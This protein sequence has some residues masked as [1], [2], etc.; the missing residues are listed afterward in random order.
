M[1]EYL[2]TP[3]PD[4]TAET[5]ADERLAAGDIAGAQ[6][7]LETLGQDFANPDM[8]FHAN[9]KAYAAPLYE[10]AHYMPTETRIRTANDTYGLMASLIELEL[11][12]ARQ[13][14]KFSVE[15]GE[16]PRRVGRINELLVFGLL[17]REGIDI[18]TAAVPIPASR[19]DDES[20]GIDFYLSPV[21][22]GRLDDG[23]PFQV[24][25]TAT[26]DD[27]KKFSEKGIALISV[28]DID[29]RFASNPDKSES[30]AWCMLRELDGKSSNQ[31]EERLKLATAAVYEKIANTSAVRQPGGRHWIIRK[32]ARRFFR[33]QEIEGEGA[34]E[35]TN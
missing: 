8:F 23:W 10:L 12:S 3:R 19:K 33:L 30:L 29:K 5:A 7:I 28:A 4:R 13:T 26:E 25:T 21:G 2:K 35:W 1:R 32:L 6:R 15:S 22:T 20:R 27:K 16:K 14:N 34:L 18:H 9:F 24:K 11:L 31:D 17:I